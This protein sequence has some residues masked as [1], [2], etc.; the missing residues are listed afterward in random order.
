MHTVTETAT[1]EAAGLRMALRAYRY[2]WVFY[3]RTWRGTIVISV[4]NPLLFLLAIGAGLGRLI[5]PESATLGGVEYLAFFAPGMLAA[6]S[7]QNGII[8]SAF[9]VSRSRM[10]DGAYPVAVA[11]PL[12][13]VDVLHGHALFM[14]VRVTM[15][16]TAFFLVM[17]A[18]GVARSSSVALALPAATLTGMA[19]ALPTAAWAV[20]LRDVEPVMTIFKWVVMPLYL[21]SGTFFSVSQ[22]PSVLQPIVEVTP[23]WHGVELCRTLTLGTATWSGSLVH[24]A[25]LACLSG[26]GYLI[27]RRNYRRHLHA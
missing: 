19:F 8:E 4:A 22:L 7:M 3:K 2:W 24:V 9:P 20:T 6:A 10:S 23:L 25:Y 27:A 17:L 13:P 14:A 21:F 16:A 5:S 12:E 1:H 18:F 11:T 15:S 26:V